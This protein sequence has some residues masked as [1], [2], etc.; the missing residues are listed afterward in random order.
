QR[1]QQIQPA[2]QN[3]L[4]YSYYQINNLSATGYPT[5][6]TSIQLI[7]KDGIAKNMTSRSDQG[8]V[9]LMGTNEMLL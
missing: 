7:R 9:P 2:I 3:V 4:G 1:L 8:P 6:N 5:D